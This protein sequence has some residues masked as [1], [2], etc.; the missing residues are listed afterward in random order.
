MDGTTRPMKS[1][2]V[3]NVQ[4]LPASG[5]SIPFLYSRWIPSIV[6]A[7]VLVAAGTSWSC[8]TGDQYPERT[9]LKAIMVSSKSTRLM[10][11]YDDNDDFAHPRS[12]LLRFSNKGVNIRD[13]VRQM[14]TDLQAFDRHIAQQKVLNHE[15]ERVVS[16]MKARFLSDQQIV[17]DLLSS[18]LISE[19]DQMDQLESS[20]IQ[21]VSYL[22]DLVNSIQNDDASASAGIDAVNASYT[23]LNA[24]QDLP[25]VLLPMK[26]RALSSLDLHA[27]PEPLTLCARAYKG[28]GGY[29]AGR[30]QGR[31]EPDRLQ[32]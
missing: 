23:A 11:G 13:R 22:Q 16:E 31:D 24:S 28:A 6:C 10:W 30:R 18:G 20:S 26:Y 21:N 8:W 14:E 25:E 27:L 29:C 5:R 9:E 12:E 2:T 4:S 32:H 17:R 3:S 19:S 7:V 15:N 1:N